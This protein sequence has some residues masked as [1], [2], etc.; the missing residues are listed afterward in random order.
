MRHILIL[1]V[2]MA[3][4]LGTQ[5]SRGSEQ[6]GESRPGSYCKAIRTEAAKEVKAEVAKTDAKTKTEVTQAE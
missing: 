1:G 5:V 2:V 3:G 4:V 6:L